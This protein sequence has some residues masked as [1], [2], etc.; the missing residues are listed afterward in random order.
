MEFQFDPLNPFPFYSYMRR[1]RPVFRDDTGLWHVFRYEDVRKVLWDWPKFSSEFDVG[2]GNVISGTI[3]NLDPPKHD[4]LRA[5]VA[6]PFSPEKVGKLEPKIRAIVEELLLRA[7]DRG[8]MDVIRDLA[9]PLPVMVIADMLGLPREDM[10]KFKEWTDNLVGVGNRGWEVIGELLQYLEGIVRE[11]RVSPKGDLVS[12]LLGSTVDGDKLNERELLGFTVLLLIAGNET[13]TNLIGNAV[14]TILERP[15]LTKTLRERPEL[16]TTAVEE[17][18]RFRSP[19]QAMF[20]AVK[21]DVE[22]SGSRMGKGD[23]VLAWIGSANRD[24]EKFPN[25]DEFIADRKPNPHL[26]FGTG[27]HTC[28]GA[29]LARLEGRIALSSLLQSF[30]NMRLKEE[31]VEPLGNGIFYGLKRL[32]VILG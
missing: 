14:L 3:I 21:E 17:F 26:A 11:R 9:I 31:R 18:L 25:P 5:L 7:K 19:V 32:N 27:V 1:N 8:E 29:P 6:D 28:L 30:P 10:W 13:T 12:I 4:R 20:R 15:G 23:Q 16:M 22:I 2:E 24:E